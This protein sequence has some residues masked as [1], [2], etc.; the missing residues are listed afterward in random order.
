MHLSHHLYSAKA[1]LRIYCAVEQKF[2]RKSTPLGLMVDIVGAG[3]ALI[4]VGFGIIIASI[5]FSRSGKTDVKGGGVILIGP[6]PIIFG[7]DAKWATIAIILAVI[8]VVLSL[9]LYLA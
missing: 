4:L 7:S 8:L 5:A 2:Y 1:R 3:I 9:L 6:I